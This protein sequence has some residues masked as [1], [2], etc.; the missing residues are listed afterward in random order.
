MQ[1]KAPLPDALAKIAAG[2]DHIKTSE[3]AH[4]VNR[5]SQTVR[6]NYCLTGEC[7]GIRPVKVGNFL[8]W[9]VADTARL[10]SGGVN[11]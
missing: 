3:F 10:L 8:L 2:R 6:K 7:F 4:A 9:P 11:A 1:T 5:A